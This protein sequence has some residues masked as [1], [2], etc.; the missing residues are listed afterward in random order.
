MKHNSKSN[1]SSTKKRIAI[2]GILLLIIL[3]I[4]L[5]LKSC[6]APSQNNKTPLP[7]D[8][9][10]GEYVE[11]PHD[12]IHSQNIILPGWG[13]ITIDADKTYIDSGVD[14]YN[15][16][17]NLWYKCPDCDDELK[18]KD[19][20]L[21]CKHC[22]KEVSKEQAIED[23][24]YM[25]FALY[26]GN[27][28]DGIDNSELLYKSDL[29]SPNMHIQHITLNRPLSKNNYDAFI[30]IQPYMS[31]MASECNRGI[32]NLDKGLIVN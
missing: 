22:D 31:D 6:S 21:Y 5:L 29:V 3:I 12:I 19:E 14:F 32:V 9:N 28:K 20:M 11:P 27:P 23:C 25:S 13:T 17:G 26:L 7:S 18:E 1:S 24:Y 30:V 2:I 10:Q 16:K 4:L 15:P 8:P